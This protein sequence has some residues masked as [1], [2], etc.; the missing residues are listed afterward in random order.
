MKKIK[1][2][3]EVVSKQLLAVE[4]ASDVILYAAFLLK[5][6]LEELTSRSK[7]GNNK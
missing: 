1:G 4:N 3:K 2:K 6:L 5:D 7:E